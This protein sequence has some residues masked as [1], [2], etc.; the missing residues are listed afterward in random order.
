MK[1]LVVKIKQGKIAF[2]TIT[3]AFFDDFI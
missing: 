2:Y 1:D 3:G